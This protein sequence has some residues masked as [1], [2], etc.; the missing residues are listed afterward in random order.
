[1]LDSLSSQTRPPD[2]LIVGD[3]LSA[4]GTLKMLERFAGRVSFPVVV[5][6][7]GER[8]GLH[9]NTAAILGRSCDVADV[10]AL[11]D[12]DDVWAADKLA[13]VEAA[14]TQA[15]PP[16]LWF[17][18]A[19][20]IDEVGAPLSVRLFDKVHLS[21]DDR[22][23]LRRGGGLRRLVYGQTVTSPT[24]A[25]AADLVPHCLPFP[26]D[27]V[28]GDRAF[29]QDGWVAVLA[30]VRGDVAIDERP[31]I[32]YRQHGRQMSHQERLES[33]SRAAGSRRE[34]LEREQRRARLVADRV[35]R[36]D[37]AWHPDRRDEILALDRFLSARIQRG[38]ILARVLAIG[39]E[40]GAGSYHRFAR[41]ARTVLYDL[42]YAFRS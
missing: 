40:V 10:V 9:R 36:D 42:V 32:A 41:G 29:Q 38:G 1:M 7:H 16:A 11:A 23:E 21:V 4:D 34:D 12:H 5:V 22:A 39:R 37:G 24:M 30:R 8:L 25:F 14:F 35:R 13:A 28:A 20:L 27:V 17:S 15:T 2:V 19:E 3:D 18:D 6:R 33:S 26:E 31:L